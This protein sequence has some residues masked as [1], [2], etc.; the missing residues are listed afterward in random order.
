MQLMHRYLYRYIDRK[1]RCFLPILSAHHNNRG[2]CSFKRPYSTRALPTDG[3]LWGGPDP[4]FMNGTFTI[5]RSHDFIIIY[6]CYSY[7]P[8]RS[9]LHCHAYVFVY[10][11]NLK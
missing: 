9:E 2:P 7:A 1:Y 6:Y 8:T 10:D 11:L 4:G 3:A 5:S